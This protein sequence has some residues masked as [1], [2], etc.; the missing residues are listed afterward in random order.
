MGNLGEEKKTC[1]FHYVGLEYE[2]YIIPYWDPLQTTAAPSS[3]QFV[4]L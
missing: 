1:F 2:G 3:E 4:F